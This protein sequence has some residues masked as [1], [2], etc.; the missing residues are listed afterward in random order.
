MLPVLKKLKPLMSLL[1][2]KPQ[3]QTNLQGRRSRG[4]ERDIP[5]ISSNACHTPGDYSIK[6]ERP[7]PPRGPTLLYNIF[8]GNGTPLVYLPS[9]NS[10]HFHMS[11]SELFRLLATSHTLPLFYDTYIFSHG[12]TWVKISR[13]WKF[14]LSYI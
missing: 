2:A 5:E 7:I 1:Q 6:T 12:Y 9:K 13:Q 10:R 4:K 3:R 14:T 11:R 8:D